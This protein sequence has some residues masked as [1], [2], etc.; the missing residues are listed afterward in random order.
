M[1]Q[2]ARRFLVILCTLALVSGSTISF[3]AS[4]SAAEPCVH[5]HHQHGGV[6]PAQHDHHGLGCLT[7]CQGACAAVAGLPTP[8]SVTA[9]IFAATAV[10]YWETDVSLSDRSIAPDPGPPRTIA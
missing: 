3:A 10:T 2:M 9:V 7:C 8:S 4:V 5:E 6:V 1:W